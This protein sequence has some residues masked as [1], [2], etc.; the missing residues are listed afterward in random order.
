MK[1]LD[2]LGHVK[3]SKHDKRLYTMNDMA[4]IRRDQAVLNSK[5]KRGEMKKLPNSISVCRC[6]AE[7]CFGHTLRR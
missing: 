2:E 5:V 3:Y 7:G 6:G 4:Q 1:Q